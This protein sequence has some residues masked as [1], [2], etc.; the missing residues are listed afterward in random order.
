MEEKRSDAM[1]TVRQYNTGDEKGILRLVK[2]ALPHTHETV[3][4]WQWRHG[5]Q[6]QRIFVAVHEKKGIIGHWAYLRN[7]L[8]WQ[9]KKYR[10][11]LTVTAIV[12]P[13]WQGQNIFFQLTQALFSFANKEKIDV[14]YAFPNDLAAPSHAFLGFT[15]IKSYY[16][17]ACP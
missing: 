10:A 1:V 17:Y 13:Q 11:G 5:K 8:E 12:H 6:L 7:D 14:L 16:L 15:P 4:Q 9:N 3:T 2:V